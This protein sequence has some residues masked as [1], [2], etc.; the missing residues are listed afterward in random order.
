MKGAFTT[1]WVQAYAEKRGLQVELGTIA[2]AGFRE[3][4]LIHDECTVKLTLAC[5][6]EDGRAQIAILFTP[7][8]VAVPAAS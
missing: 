1:V 3:R 8:Q 6:G 7:P 5:V 4:Q 2:D